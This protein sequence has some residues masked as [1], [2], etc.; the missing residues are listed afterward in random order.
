M[1]DDLP[2]PRLNDTIPRFH[3]TPARFAQLHAARASDEHDRAR[4]CTP[5]IEWALAYEPAAATLTCLEKAGDVPERVTHNDTKLNNV[6]FDPDTGEAAC[7]IDLDTVM[8]G[9][10]L[11]D[12]G[13][14]VRTATMPVAEDTTNLAAVTMRMD[15]YEALVEGY[16]ESTAQLLTETE[17]EYLAVSGKIITIESAVRFLTD[18]LTGDRYFRTQRPEQN[19]DRCRTQFALAAR[20]DEQLAEMQDVTAA[21]AARHASGAAQP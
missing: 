18:Y 21:V 14:M 17:L 9:L 7:V 20:I 10:A 19:L 13:D 3:D 6:M 12:F 16:L 11:Y 8:P 1:L 5:E 4:H 15:C 2:G